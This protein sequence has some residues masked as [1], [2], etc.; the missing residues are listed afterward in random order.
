MHESDAICSKVGYFFNLLILLLHALVFEMNTDFLACVNNINDGLLSIKLIDLNNRLITCHDNIK[1]LCVMRKYFYTEKSQELDTIISVEAQLKSE[2]MEEKYRSKV[3]LHYCHEWKKN[4]ILQWIQMLLDI[5]Q[6][7]A[8]TIQ[9]YE[10]ILKQTAMVHQETIKFFTYHNNE[11]KLNANKWYDYYQNET[12]RF[13]KELT[14]LQQELLQTKKR[15]QYMYEDYQRMKT[16]VDENNQ[17]QT[18]KRLLLEKQQQQQEAIRCIQT[19]W[20]GIMIRQIRRKRHKKK[21]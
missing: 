4:H 6:D 17:I 10:N 2:L 1:K 3:S 13:D 8:K 11:M 12:Y 7:Y 14:S 16:I 5:E 20:R 19:W 9:E 18:N 21:K 15:K